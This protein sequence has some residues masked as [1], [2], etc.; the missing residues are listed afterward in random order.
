MECDCEKYSHL[1][2][3][4]AAVDKRIKETKKIKKTL[5]KVSSQQNDWY[6]LWKC[7][8]C[9]QLWQSSGAWNWGAREYIYK[10]PEISIE[11][12]LEEPFVKPDEML[13]YSAFI[14]DFLEKGTFTE[15]AQF[16]KRE[17][18]SSRAIQYSVLCKIH[19][20]EYLFPNSPKGRMFEPYHFRY[21]EV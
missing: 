13:I 20:I 15:R 8:V 10:V 17:H 19:H 3:Y 5:E 2:L 12:W 18:C 4:R 14:H 21:K 9:N 11:N 7:P 6:N 1:E 16:C